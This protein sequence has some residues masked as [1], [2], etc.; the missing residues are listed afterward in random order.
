MF[1][2]APSLQNNPLLEAQD[3]V[4]DGVLGVGGGVIPI[5][6]LITPT[7]GSWDGRPPAFHTP[8]SFKAEELK[9]A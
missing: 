6:P 1:S 3:A 5:H 2:V 4:Q 8:S 9:R 7:E